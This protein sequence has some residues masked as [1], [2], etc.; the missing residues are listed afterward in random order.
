MGWLYIPL[1][2]SFFQIVKGECT[3]YIKVI[4]S[5][6]FRGSDFLW[7]RFILHMGTLIWVDMINIET[8]LPDFM[9]LKGIRQSPLP[10]CVL[11]IVI[12]LDHLASTSSGYY[13]NQL[14]AID[15]LRS[16]TCLHSVCPPVAS[17]VSTNR[18]FVSSG[19]GYYSNS[20][21]C[22]TS[23]LEDWGDTVPHVLKADRCWAVSSGIP[24]YCMGLGFLCLFRKFPQTR[25]KCL[26]CCYCLTMTCHMELIVYITQLLI[27]TSTRCS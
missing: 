5:S 9:K 26:T 7:G 14:P 3:T 21:A 2:S 19:S 23:Y 4:H 24:L 20:F 8:K 13:M 25:A 10:Q 1:G 16:C 15:R 6:L 12:S 11:E 27:G 22:I 17:D 18:R